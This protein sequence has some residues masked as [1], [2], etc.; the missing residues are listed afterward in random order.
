M[1][2][3]SPQG[4]GGG[5]EGG[6]ERSRLEKELGPPQ[7]GTR[8][9]QEETRGRKNLEAEQGGKPAQMG[10]LPQGDKASFDGGNSLRGP[11]TGL[12]YQMR[13]AGA[14]Q[15][16]GRRGGGTSVGFSLQGVN[17]ALP[18]AQSGLATL[19]GLATGQAQLRP[20]SL[21]CELPKGWDGGFFTVT[22][23]CLS[24]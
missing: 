22:E 10:S 6:G 13:Q 14:F 23:S 17:A 11:R 19:D 18:A 21:G 2:F 4:G 5:G 12:G 24:S 8:A 15:E 16:G 1:D 20:P 9:H 3:L 7:P